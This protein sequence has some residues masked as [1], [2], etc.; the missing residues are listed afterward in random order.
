MCGCTESQHQRETI[1]AWMQGMRS[2]GCA[3]VLNVTSSSQ[4]EHNAADVHEEFPDYP[5][6]ESMA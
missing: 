6:T 2:H 1:R 4:G 3:G 5:N